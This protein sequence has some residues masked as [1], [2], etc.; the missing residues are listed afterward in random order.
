MKLLVVGG[1]SGLGLAISERFGGVAVSTR[2]GH[3]IPENIDR[4]IEISLE[5][6]VVIN[7]LPDSNQNKLLFPMYEAHDKKKLST[8]FITVGSMSW[9]FHTEEHSKRALFDWAETLILK[10]TKLKHTLVNPAY[11]WNSKNQGDMTP[12]SSKEMLDTI[13]FLLQNRYNDSVISLLE[14][15]GQHINVNR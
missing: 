8:Y 13:D 12:I 14:I 11:L 1:T 2:T 7:C 9:R 6:D 10:D 4:V 15:K 3:G 5:Y